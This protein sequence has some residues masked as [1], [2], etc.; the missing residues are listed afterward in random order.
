MPQKR[1]PKL[2]RGVREVRR[3]ELTIDDLTLTMLTALGKGNA[4]A[5]ARHAARVAYRVYQAT[6][7]APAT[8]SAAEIAGTT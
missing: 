2:E 4:S 6:S 3:V 7:D 5:G 8:D 1:G